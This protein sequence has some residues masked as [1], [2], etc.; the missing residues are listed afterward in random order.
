MHGSLVEAWLH[1]HRGGEG[2]RPGERTAVTERMIEAGLLDF[3]RLHG[4]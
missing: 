3:A 2:A 1:R 4:R